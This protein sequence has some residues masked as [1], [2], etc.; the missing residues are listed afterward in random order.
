[1]VWTEEGVQGAWRFLNRVWRRV[2]EDQEALLAISGQFQAEALEGEDKALY[3]KLHETLKKVT[4]DLE[5]LRFNTAIA[6]LMEL[7]N[8][9]Y[10]YRRKRPVT[11]VYRTAIRYYLQMLFPFAPHIAEELW[12]RFWPDSLFEA[13]WP[14][15]DES[16]L[17]RDV[18]EVAVQVNGRVRGTIRISKDAPLEVA[19]AEAK[20]VPNVQA[21]LKG[22]EVMKEIYVPGKILN[23]VVR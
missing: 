3:G 22:K 9:L 1:M 15:L 19:L 2:V 17:E 21:H 12:H 20:K 10:E 5:A 16:A 18:V 7:L 8:A 6:A 11:P 14:E 23:L 4:Q 13:G